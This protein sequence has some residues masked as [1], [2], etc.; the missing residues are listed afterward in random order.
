MIINAS[1]TFVVK[2]PITT[3]KILLPNTIKPTSLTSFG[4][5]LLAFWAD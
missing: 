1:Y 2:S 3:E 4:L 5:G